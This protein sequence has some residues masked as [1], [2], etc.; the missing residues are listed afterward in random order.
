[1]PVEMKKKATKVILYLLRMN[2]KRPLRI[3]KSIVAIKEVTPQRQ[4]KKSKMQYMKNIT[5][6][7]RSKRVAF[8][9]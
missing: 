7:K 9:V 4:M 6:R 8:K 5:L 1:V 3:S 2:L